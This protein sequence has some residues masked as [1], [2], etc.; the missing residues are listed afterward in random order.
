MDK[1]EIESW[2]H[3]EVAKD[4]HDIRQHK[5]RIIEEIKKT[6]I[7]EV[8]EKYSNSEEEPPKP[9]KENKGIWKKIKNTLKF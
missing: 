8:L 6:N 7:H 9:P 4:Q 3:Q 5:K 2:F 1:K